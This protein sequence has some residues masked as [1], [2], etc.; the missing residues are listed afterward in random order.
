MLLKSYEFIIRIII[1][2]F[3]HSAHTQFPK[4]L[5]NN[6]WIFL[7]KLKVIKSNS[8]YFHRILLNYM[9]V[10]YVKAAPKSLIQLS[11]IRVIVYLNLFIVIFIGVWNTIQMLRFICRLIFKVQQTKRCLLM[12]AIQ[13]FN[14]IR[15]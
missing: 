12:L 9:G 3:T 6:C 7:L 11:Q 15:N 1:Y 14:L 2:N 8:Y 5:N 4:I 13:L 10:F